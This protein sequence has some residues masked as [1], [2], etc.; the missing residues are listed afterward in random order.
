MKRKRLLLVYN[1][2]EIQRN[3]L[4]WYIECIKNLL[5]QEYDNFQVVVSGCKVTDATKKG[6]Y[7]TFGNRIWYN[8]F[9]DVYTV[10]VTFNHTVKVVSESCGKFDGYIYIDSGMNA[11][12]NIRALQEVNIRLQTE[13]YGIV[14]LQPSTDTGYQMWFGKPEVGFAFTGN[15][16]IIPVGKACPLHF[17]CFDHKMVEYYGRPLPDIFKMCCSESTYSFLCA[18]LKLQWVIVKDLVLLHWKALDGISSFKD[19]PKTKEHWNDLICGLDLKTLVLTPEGKKLGM[20]F[21]EAQNIF[22][23]D[24]TCFDENGLCKNDNLKDF[25]KK[26]LFVPPEIIDYNKINSALIYA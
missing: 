8:F 22:M 7:K 16:F 5:K 6:L 18:A 25:I 24:P 23:H 15:D 1:I 26:T 19:D 11:A 9:D 21:E 20:G 3:N 4:F 13:K 12:D 17:T 14:S 10:F 2:C